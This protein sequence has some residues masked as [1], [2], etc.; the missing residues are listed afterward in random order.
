M[1]IAKVGKEPIKIKRRRTKL[2][3]RKL[4]NYTRGE[5]IF[6]MVSHIV[7]GGI[8]VVTLALCVIIAAVKGNAAGVICGAVFGASMIALYT[9]SSIYHGLRAGMAKRV[10]QVL[11]HCTIYFL[12]AGTYTPMLICCLAKLYPIHACL[13]FAFVWGLTALAI[14]LTAVDMEKYNAF[15]MITYVGMGWAIIFSIKHMFEAVGLLGFILLLGGGVLYT[16][17]VI[18][19]RIG[20][21]KRY[22]H[23]IFHLFVL[24]GSVAHSLCVMLFAL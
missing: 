7:G 2:R 22:F 8:G 1:N 11:D 6:N 19:F 23:S 16:V 21:N 3:D 4:P 17:G 10:F 18:F 13:T 15:S 5:E 14:T 20:I 12:I 24:M 9:V